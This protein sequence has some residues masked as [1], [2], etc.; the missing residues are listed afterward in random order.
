MLTRK[1]A[2]ESI[3]LYRASASAFGGGAG[4]DEWLDTMKRQAGWT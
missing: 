4:K 2:Q 3:E 1:A